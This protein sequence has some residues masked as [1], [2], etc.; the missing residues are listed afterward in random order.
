MQGSFKLNNNIDSYKTYGVYLAGGAYAKIV[1]LPGFKTIPAVDW[2][3]YDGMEYDLSDVRL[4]KREVTLSIYASS[5]DGLRGFMRYIMKNVS[6]Q[7]EFPLIGRGYTLRFL[8][9]S[10]YKEREGLISMSLIFSE[11]I[12]F[13]VEA[14]PYDIA[15]IPESRYA[16]DGI[17]FSRFGCYI[18]S[19]TSDSVEKPPAVKEGLIIN[20]ADNNG[21]ISNSPKKTRKKTST[22][23]L[24]CFM[25]EKNKDNFNKCF[26]ALA[27]QLTKAGDHVLTVNTVHIPCHYSSLNVSSLAIYDDEIWFKFNLELISHASGLWDDSF[28]ITEQ[29]EEFIKTENGKLIIR[30]NGQ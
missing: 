15:P 11:D 30:E 20:T 28:F 10:S 25:K 3:E 26:N 12:P 5:K 7:Y 23:T 18:L 1:G 17:N 19:G 27:Y 6:G 24:S 8:R 29:E 22:M 21:V 16:I 13:I 2:A 4:D 14:A 9:A